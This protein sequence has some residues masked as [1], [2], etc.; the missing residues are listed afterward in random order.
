MA[1]AGVASEA[2]L[3]GARY[4]IG[5]RMSAVTANSPI[6]ITVRPESCLAGVV[7]PLADGVDVVGTEAEAWEA[8]GEGVAVRS[9]AWVFWT[10]AVH[11]FCPT[12]AYALG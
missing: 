7:V 5:Y 10:V 11:G 6:H 2:V 3:D 12:G 8:G 9:I 4:R 1:V